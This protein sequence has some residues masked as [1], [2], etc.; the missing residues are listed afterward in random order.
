VSGDWT[1][2]DHSIRPWKHGYRLICPGCGHEEGSKK[3][4]EVVLL[5]GASPEPNHKFRKCRECREV[6]PTRELKRQKSQYNRSWIVRCPRCS[7]YEL[8][9]AAFPEVIFE[10]D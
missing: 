5:E 9:V 3:L 1:K 2:A 6:F 8:F 7:H 10:D 4:G